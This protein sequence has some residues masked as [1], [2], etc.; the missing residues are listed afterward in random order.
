MQELS[1]TPSTAAP[2]PMPDI[3]LQSELN[4]SS[5]G[6]GSTPSRFGMEP[7]SPPAATVG[8][9]TTMSDNVK[10]VKRDDAK[11]NELDWDVYTVDNYVPPEGAGHPIICVKDTYDPRTKH[12]FLLFQSMMLRAYKRRLLR[13]FLD[14]VN[15]IH[16]GGHRVP[17]LVTYN[18][19]TSGSWTM[20]DNVKVWRGGG[21][22][23]LRNSASVNVLAWCLSNLS[24]L[25]PRKQVKRPYATNAR[26]DNLL[27]DL[28]QGVD[29]LERAGHTTFWEWPDRSKPL[30]SD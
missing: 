16:D 8:Q 25:Q 22:N 26:H 2:I 10:A 6:L 13:G 24:R 11:V 7:D 29:C 14:H 5:S 30:S 19:D 15:K 18:L 20:V 21:G 27:R 3:L 23:F 9:S 12:F 17:H 28:T 4:K 1:Q